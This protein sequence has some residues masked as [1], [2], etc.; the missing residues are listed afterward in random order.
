[1][2]AEG[3]TSFERRTCSASAR[4]SSFLLR[5]SFSPMSVNSSAVVP[6]SSQFP[7]WGS[8][9]KA[10]RPFGAFALISED[11]VSRYSRPSPAPD[12]NVRCPALAGS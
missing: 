8:V 2:T 10:P 5:C 12:P 4:S 1:M 9:A 7:S 11:G 3:V 6:S